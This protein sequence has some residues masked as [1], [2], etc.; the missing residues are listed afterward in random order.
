MVIPKV[1]DL[2]FLEYFSKMKDRE[3]IDGILKRYYSPNTI[4]GWK[5]LNVVLN[6]IVACLVFNFF[7][8]NF[9]VW[10]LSF[11][12][13]DIVSI[14]FDYIFVFII[15]K[16]KFYIL[17]L[18]GIQ[19]YISDLESE[20]AKVRGN[21]CSN[22]P[23]G[24]HCE[25]L[26][27]YWCRDDEECSMYIYFSWLTKVK[28]LLEVYNNIK[29]EE[30]E[31][32]EKEA[33]EAKRISELD[34]KFVDKLEF[35]ENVKCRISKYSKSMKLESLNKMENTVSELI[36]LLK[37]KTI[38]FKLIP[39]SLN[40]YLTEFLDV[41]EK[42]SNLD[43]KASKEYKNKLMKI[44]NALSEDVNELNE[45]IRTFEVNDIDVTLKVLYDELVEDDE[46][47]GNE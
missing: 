39:N 14:F 4:S 26:Q 41:V 46:K 40:I 13:F 3:E 19:K 16:L 22:S 6:I 43:S 37:Q 42:V 20:I 2:T 23:C 10:A 9:I 33:E 32:I 36:S 15:P 8:F 17:G 30:I 1:D 31:K 47:V 12:I 28:R 29:L 38:G 27:N 25:K 18:K 35:Y 24:H 45:R 5:F 34:K 44:A 11:V 7:K 21:L